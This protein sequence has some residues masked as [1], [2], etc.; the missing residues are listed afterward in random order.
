MTD[1]SKTDPLNDP[2][3]RL[4]ANLPLV[5]GLYPIFIG[6]YAAGLFWDI[7][8]DVV[9]FFGVEDFLF[10]CS[11]LYATI[12]GGV[13]V[14]LLIMSSIYAVA[15]EPTHSATKTNTAAEPPLKWKEMKRSDRIRNAFVSASIVVLFGLTMF[16]DP[17]VVG[18]NPD[19]FMTA[20]FIVF[21]G[22]L[23]ARPFLPE[24]RWRAAGILYLFT[25]IIVA[26]LLAGYSDSKP[27]TDDARLRVG[28]AICPVVLVGGKSLLARCGPRLVVVSRDQVKAPLVWLKRT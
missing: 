9:G 17:P 12:I 14:P 3:A 4:R 7:P 13:L 6:L 8:R 18:M 10:R 23:V 24:E 26:P 21:V 25:W 11:I 16:L 19:G 5:L 1:Q 27:N 22:G 2:L 28:K 20:L 15:L